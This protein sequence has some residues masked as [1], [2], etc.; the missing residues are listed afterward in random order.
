M[1]EQ[2]EYSVPTSSQPDLNDKE[3][4]EPDDFGVKNYRPYNRGNKLKR[5]VEQPAIVPTKPTLWAI[6]SID[7]DME[8]RLT[9]TQFGHIGKRRAIVRKGS[10]RSKHG[11]AEGGDPYAGI[12]IDEIWAQPE[13]PEDV[14]KI[15]SARHTL[16]NRQLKI[17]SDSAMGMI[18][19]EKAFSR[20]I[21]RFAQL[22]Q[23]DDP[24]SQDVNFEET[25]PADVLKQLRENVQDLMSCSNEYVDRIGEMRSKLLRAYQQ[26]KSIARRL[27]PFKQEDEIITR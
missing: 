10:A 6:H 9:R 13:K 17:L 24:L 19:K 15:R 22:I 26:K 18:E 16:R 7:E 4:S 25:V 12:N 5:A 27:V 21:S 11:D 8:L 2:V 14:G 3:E 1:A 23:Q 20:R